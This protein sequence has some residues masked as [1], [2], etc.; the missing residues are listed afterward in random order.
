MGLTDRLTMTGSRVR[1]PRRTVRLRLTLL[2]SSL[3]LAAGAALLAITYFLMRSTGN[4]VLLGGPKTSPSAGKHL[5]TVTPQGQIR[6][7]HSSSAA[8]PPD[9]GQIR[10]LEAQALSQHANDLHRL[11]IGSGI[12]L[13]IMAVVAVGLGW[14]VAGRVLRPLRTMTTATQQI[15]EH[16]LHQRLALPGPSDEIKDLADTID[17][18]LGRLE[19]AFDAQRRF[20]DNA[21]HELRTPLTLNRALLD[22]TLANPDATNQELRTMGQ[23]LITSGEQQEGLI[24]ALLT[25]ATSER[26]LDIHE[27]L[28]LAAIAET[29]LHGH[30]PQINR[31]GLDVQSTLAPAPTTGNPGLIERLVANLLDNALRYNTT[32]GF[33]SVTSRTESG[34]ASL[35]ITNSGPNIPPE[36]ID[37]LF[38]AFQRL[39]TNRTRHPGGHGLG[40][41]I[42]QAVAAAHGATITARSRPQGGLSIEVTFPPVIDS[43]HPARHSETRNLPVSNHDQ[44]TART[45]DNKATSDLGPAGNAADRDSKSPNGS[46][47]GTESAPAASTRWPPKDGRRVEPGRIHAAVTDRRAATRPA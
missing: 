44:P 13:A 47:T 7:L 1:L 33:V 6:G 35:T 29:V 39:N 3:F 19:A 25:L 40:L 18:L 20:V 32:G 43:T 14:F 16:N 8:P 15:T 4:F 11:L 26:G 31:L 45:G 21:S 27:P 36:D 22:V 17:G 42:V 10:Q 38:Q 23:E 9:I 37:R 24:E 2:Y 5:Y 12:A 28:D 46:C 41:S 34:R 30:H